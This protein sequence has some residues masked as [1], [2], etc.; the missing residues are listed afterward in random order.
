MGLQFVAQSYSMDAI[1]RR[2]GDLAQHCEV[3]P[4]K[5]GYYG[6]S[7]PTR[8]FDSVGEARIYERIRALKR[9]DLYEG[10]WAT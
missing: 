3:F 9:F 10:I 8:I 1:E 6:V 4:L 7:I 2:L 5:L